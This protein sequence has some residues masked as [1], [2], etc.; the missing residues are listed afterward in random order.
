MSSQGPKS[1]AVSPEGSLVR[2]KRVR[3]AGWA[4]RPAG[5]P[6]RLGNTTQSTKDYLIGARSVLIDSDH[7]KPDLD[8]LRC[9]LLITL[10]LGGASHKTTVSRITSSN[11]GRMRRFNHVASYPKSDLLV[12]LRARLV[13]VVSATRFVR[14]CRPSRIDI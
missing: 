2:G 11:L 8:G 6:H 5:Y 4:F 10:C 14:I 12:I 13:E 7:I 3:L 9:C 1:S